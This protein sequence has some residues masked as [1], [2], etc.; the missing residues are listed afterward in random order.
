LN[1]PVKISII[2]PVFN[3]ETFINETIHKIKKQNISSYEIIIVDDGSTDSSAQIIQQQD[4]I[5]YIFKEN[6]GP[7]SA[8]NLGINQ[9][10]G[11]YIIFLDSDDYWEDG[12]LALLTDYL[13]KHPT[14]Q[15]IEGKI[16]EFKSIPNTE[17]FD[18]SPESY[19][20]SNFG[21]CMIRREVFEIIGNFNET[22]ICSE[23][24]DWYTRAWEN[25]IVKDR[26]DTIVLNYR[27]HAESITSKTREKGHFYRLLLF[28][29]KI[30]REKNRDY[31]PHGKLID[32]IGKR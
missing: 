6:G 3:S 25:N 21:S 8:R 32:Y 30:E 1:S 7:A 24:I 14:T 12:S 26:I 20:M 9:A 22:L 23:D 15:I 29:L 31:I 11:T 18:F 5:L 2:I 4:E 19:F 13:D 27:K 16:R 17:V 10:K 28:K